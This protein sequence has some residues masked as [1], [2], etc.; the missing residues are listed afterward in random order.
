MVKCVKIKYVDSNSGIRQLLLLE[1]S[2]RSNNDSR[3]I[4]E[5]R[6]NL[7][8]IC[9]FWSKF[10]IESEGFGYLEKFSAHLIS[11]F[12]LPLFDRRGTNLH[13]L[14]AGF[15]HGQRTRKTSISETTLGVSESR[16][17]DRA[18]RACPCQISFDLW[19]LEG[20]I[21]KEIQ[22]YTVFPYQ[23]EW[24]RYCFDLKKYI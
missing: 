19:L 14:W 1:F 16:S 10:F 7:N 18:N 8:A 11:V 4:E 24:L 20:R 9:F 13:C 2:Q 5:F 21:R 15:L 3:I 23:S 17:L 6:K 22:K 12:F